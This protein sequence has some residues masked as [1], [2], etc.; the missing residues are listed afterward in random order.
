M[1]FVI[2]D[3]KIEQAI[4]AFFLFSFLGWLLEGLLEFISGRGFINRGFFFGPIVPIYAFGFFLA[5]TI[6]MFFKEYPVIV[7]FY[8]H[9]C[10]YCS[11]IHYR[12]SA[13][14]ILKYACMG[15]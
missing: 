14:K 9:G 15:L 7:F 13:G 6:Y 8:C 3:I 4:L 10:L 11:R 5:Y 2:F 12:T 1:N